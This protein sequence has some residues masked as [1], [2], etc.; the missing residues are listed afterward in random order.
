M[1][2]ALALSRERLFLFESTAHSHASTAHPSEHSA[3]SWELTAQRAFSPR[4]LLGPRPL[5]PRGLAPEG[6]QVVRKPFRVQ[7]QRTSP[8]PFLTN[9]P[10]RTSS[11][12]LLF[13]RRH[14]SALEKPVSKC[15]SCASRPLFRISFP[16]CARCALVR[17]SSTLPRRFE[18]LVPEVRSFGRRQETC[19]AA[20]RSPACNFLNWRASFP[21]CAHISRH[22][23]MFSL[24]LNVVGL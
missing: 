14:S 21:R 17:C 20:L 5:S 18:N 7:A 4:E 22:A 8:S 2:Q 3:R 9:Y 19:R 1:P 11:L 16:R 13:F 23:S 10:R 12:P 15:R 6:S 24:S